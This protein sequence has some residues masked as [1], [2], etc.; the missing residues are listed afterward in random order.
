[1][2]WQPLVQQPGEP[3]QRVVGVVRGVG[4]G[5][6]SGQ[7]LEAAR[8][9]Q[10]TAL[11][12]QRVYVGML[13]EHADQLAGAAPPGTSDKIRSSDRPSLARAPPWRQAI[14]RLA[15]AIV[16]T[17]PPRLDRQIAERRTPTASS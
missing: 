15:R 10:E 11:P 1:M 4:D 3:A 2:T 5:Q 8:V 16:I 17:G 14:T 12:P 13:A 9:D 7:I 6:R